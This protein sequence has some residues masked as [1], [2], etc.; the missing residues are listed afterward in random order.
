M[1][2]SNKEIWLVFCVF[3]IPTTDTDRSYRYTY[4]GRNLISSLHASVSLVDF[5]FQSKSSN[6]F[7]AS[8][9]IIHLNIHHFMAVK[10]T[11]LSTINPSKP[12]TDMWSEPLTSR[13]DDLSEVYNLKSG[14]MAIYDD[15]L[16]EKKAFEGKAPAS[17]RCF[18]KR[19]SMSIHEPYFNLHFRYGK[20]CDPA[21]P[22]QTGSFHEN[23]QG[24]AVVRNGIIANVSGEL[25]SAMQTWAAWA[26]GV[27]LIST[28][29]E[30]LQGL[31]E[32]LYL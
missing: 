24:A 21:I 9:A 15:K 26:T 14:Q 23:S 28:H 2:I 1:N 20:L 5:P 25:R 10:C 32:L 18:V 3:L 6:G 7:P 13:N 12:P 27:G 19:E 31:T 16:G 29:T 4:V 22:S 11:K 30:F 8:S 17:A